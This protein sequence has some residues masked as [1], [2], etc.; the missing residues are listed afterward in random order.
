MRI[1]LLVQLVN[2]PSCI[3]PSRK[4]SF[5]AS[6]PSHQTILVRLRYARGFF[7]PFFEWR[8]HLISGMR[9]REVRL[10]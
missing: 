4:R 5:S 6:E 8:G 2:V 1:G 10:G 7:N 3:I 9:A